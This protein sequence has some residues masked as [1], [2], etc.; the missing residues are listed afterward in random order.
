M[1]FSKIKFRHVIGVF[2]LI[3][4]SPE[5][6]YLKDKSKDEIHSSYTLYSDVAYGNDPLQTIDIH[7]S[8]TAHTL[9]NKNFT[10]VYIHGGG[11]YVSDK[12][13]EMQYV[14][15]F[16][17][18]G[19]NVVNVNYKLK[20]GALVALE[21]ITKALN[22]L[23]SNNNKYQLNLDKVILAGFSVGG[24]MAATLG[25]SQNDS[26]NPFPINRKM[27]II[28]II[29]FSG[30]VDEFETVE[31]VF[32]NW[33]NEPELKELAQQVGKAMFLSSDTLSKEALLHKIQAI[34]YFD[35]N[36]PR[37]FLWSGGLDN[38][39]PAS[40]FTKFIAMLD[41]NRLKNKVMYVAD[42]QHSPNPE[43]MESA[44]RDI[45]KFLDAY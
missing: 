15:P 24:A 34:E 7:K 8:G 37:V 26:D 45:F 16:L 2:L 40:T 3:A 27:K 20:Q 11:W 28:G 23:S 25:F 36:D 6:T 21:D 4:C 10:I 19:M 43:Q 22:F 42:G 9:K 12:S 41:S 39:I 44:Y 13:G 14:Q 33:T 29:D 18:K 5:L 30:P 35:K 32:I 38:Q 17:K 31:K 1:H